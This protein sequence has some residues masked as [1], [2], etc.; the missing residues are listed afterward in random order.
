[1]TRIS[2]SD[3]SDRVFDLPKNNSQVIKTG[4]KASISDE[5]SIVLPEITPERFQTAI[6]LK[7]IQE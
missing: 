1:M 5:S 4:T 2:G 3:I 7:S 6:L